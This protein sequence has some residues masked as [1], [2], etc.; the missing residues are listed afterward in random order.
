MSASIGARERAVGALAGLA[1][2]DALGVPVE[3]EPRQARESSPVTGLRGG[4]T[5]GC[6]PGTWSDDTS[7][8]LCLAESIVLRGFDPADSGAR[9]V[10]WM[11]EGLWAARGSAFDIGGATRRAL[12]RIRS[13]MPAVMAGGRGENDN[14]NGSLMRILPAALWLGPLPEPLRFRAIASYSAVTH[15]HPRSILGCWLLALVA[16]RLLAG[17]APREAYELGM[18]EARS[19]LGGLPAPVR[20][21]AGAYARVLDGGLPE[22]PSSAVR[23]SGYVV[24]CLEASLWCLLANGDYP[25]SVLAAVNLGE[26]SDTTGAVAG[27][28]AGLA[29]GEAGI[30]REWVQGIAR[31]GEV[32]ALARRL[33]GLVAAPPPEGCYWV[34]PGKLLAGPLPADAPELG[35]ILD[36]GVD[37]LVDLTER[38]APDAKSAY[39]AALEKAEGARGTRIACRS[40]PMGDMTADR[41]AAEAALGELDSL[42]AEGRSPYLHCLGGLGRTGTVAGCYL[43]RRGLAAPAEG[44]GLVSRLRARAGLFGDSPQT[45]GQRLLIATTKPGPEAL[46]L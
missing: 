30:P 18:S 9:F 3:F 20:G 43:V 1:V 5:W 37:A 41:E 31:S 29:Y 2:G 44:A 24:H 10:A 27:G 14:G 35:S 19:F 13:G 39:A 8:A 21:E 36:A 26:D 45:E 32:L 40:A 34:L 33:G 7:L 22:L 42:L 23:G 16:A 25:S 4:G 12:G 11:D 6:P 17:E 46:S 15:G 38:G 28:L